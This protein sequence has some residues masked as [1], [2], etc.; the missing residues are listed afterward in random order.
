MGQLSLPLATAI[1]DWTSF[2]TII[3]VVLVAIFGTISYRAS[4]PFA[5]STLKWATLCGLF[6][7]WLTIIP[8]VLAYWASGIREE[9]AERR[10]KQLQQQAS[11]RRLTSDQKQQLIEAL[12]RFSGQ[13]VRVIAPQ[14]NESSDYAFDFIEVFQGANWRVVNKDTIHGITFVSY[15]HEL[16]GIHLAIPTIDADDAKKAAKALASA[17]THQRLPSSLKTQQEFNEPSVI[18]FYVGAKPFVDFVDK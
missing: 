3:F 17:L 1:S 12:K 7:A 10:V 6:I 13:P 4:P 8:A 11:P 15:D 2:A 18:E 9:Y 14:I 16:Q 5:N